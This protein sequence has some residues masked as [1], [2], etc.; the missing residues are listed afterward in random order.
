MTPGK[1]SNAVRRVDVFFYGLF[2]DK[3]LLQAEGPV[4][5]AVEIAFVPGFALRIGQR[6]ALAPEASARVYGVLMSLTLDELGQLYAAPS[7]QA[8]R[9]YA[10]LAHLVSGEVV[11]AL[12]YNLPDPRRPSAAPST[13][14]ACSPLRG[15][16]A[17]RRSTSRPRS[18]SAGS[19]VRVSRSG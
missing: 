8:Y 18:T 2:M 1:R 13:L 16:S 9:P 6:A 5:E 4:P 19:R 17:C 11:P 7:L 3:D 14:H 10:V 12:C 15:R